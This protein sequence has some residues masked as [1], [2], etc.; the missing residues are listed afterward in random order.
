MLKVTSIVVLLI[1]AFILL[2][3]MQTNMESCGYC[4]GN[5]IIIIPDPTFVSIELEWLP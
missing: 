2:T 3:A 1:I 5:D 4:G